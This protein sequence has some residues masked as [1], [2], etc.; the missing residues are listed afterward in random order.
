MSYLCRSTNNAG[1]LCDVTKC[2]S[3]AHRSTVVSARS[4]AEAIRARW[5]R[6]GPGPRQ[7]RRVSS[8]PTTNPVP[9]DGYRAP[10]RTMSSSVTIL[11]RQCQ[12]QSPQRYVVP[13]CTRLTISLSNS[14]IIGEVQRLRC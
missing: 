4:G 12:L 5:G 14:K 2:A 3:R 10:S 9:T 6:R 1:E 8:G 7:T 11:G 13:L